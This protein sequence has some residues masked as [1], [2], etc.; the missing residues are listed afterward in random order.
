MKAQT[1]LEYLII[2]AAV[3]MVA[4][5]AVYTISKN[6][7]E[8]RESLLIRTC[9][10]AAAQ[11]MLMKQIN[12]VMTCAICDLQCVD[13]GIDLITKLAPSDDSGA[14]G[15]CKKGNITEIY[16]GSEADC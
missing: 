15:C 1:G 8:N 11:C 7:D 4:G 9:Q 2:L 5:A 16:A 6:A 12:P 14:V 10:N 13:N 3:I